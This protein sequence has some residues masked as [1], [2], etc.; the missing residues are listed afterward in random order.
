L[1]PTK[2]ALLVAGVTLFIGVI[3]TLRVWSRRV[4][5]RYTR[6]P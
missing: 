4:S 5:K 1:G 2:Q 6:E 3:V